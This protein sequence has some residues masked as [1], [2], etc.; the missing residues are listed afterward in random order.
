MQLYYPSCNTFPSISF[1]SKGNSIQLQIDYNIS[2]AKTIFGNIPVHLLE[3]SSLKQLIFSINHVS[4]F[5][6]EFFLFVDKLYFN[7]YA[8]KK[9]EQRIKENILLTF[10][11]KYSI[12]NV[13]Y[14]YS[15]LEE[16]TEQIFYYFINKLTQDSLEKGL[17][18]TKSRISLLLAEVE[19]KLICSLSNYDSMTKKYLGK[20]E[21]F[22]LENLDPSKNRRLNNMLNE[23][24]KINSF[25]RDFSILYQEAYQS[26]RRSIINEKIFNPDE[27]IKIAYNTTLEEIKNSEEIKNLAYSIFLDWG[28]V[29]VYLESF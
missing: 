9:L 5:L 22:A 18:I 7:F 1:S 29:N 8:N 28:K 25:Q 10:K 6:S 26:S 2:R 27:I 17:L 16:K 20:I 3:E 19:A 23:S 15:D 4:K 24:T 14:V 13:F 21:K 11:K 12:S